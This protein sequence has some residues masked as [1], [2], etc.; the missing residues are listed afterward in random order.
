VGL[1]LGGIAAVLTWSSTVA[2]TVANFLQ[3]GTDV[4][5]KTVGEVKRELADE[6]AK[7]KRPLL[8]I[9]DDIDRL[10]PREA[11]EIFQL[12]KIN[13]DFPNLVYLLLFDRKL[14]EKSVEELMPGS[15]REFLEKIVQVPFDVPAIQQVQLEKVL[16]E[17]IDRIL[18][19]PGI[20]QRFDR[21][22]WGNLY[23]GALRPFFE[24]LRDVNRY[25][26]TLSFHAGLYKGERTFEVNPVDLIGLEVLRVFT[27]DVYSLVARNK[28]LLTSLSDRRNTDETKGRI[29]A[30]IESA[31]EGPRPMVTELMKQLFPPV[32]WALNGSL[33]GAN[34]AGTWLRDLRVCSETVFDRYFA[35]TVPSGDLPQSDVDRLLQSSADREQLRQ[36]LDSLADRGLINL[37]LERLDTFQEQIPLQNARP[38]LAGLFDVG[39]RIPKE[40]GASFAISP[41][42]HAIRIVYWYLRRIEQST[43]RL[44]VLRQAIEESAGLSLPVRFVSIEESSATRGRDTSERIVDDEGLGL[45]KELCV[46]KIEQAAADGRLA[47]NPFL[48]QVLYRWTEWGGSGPAKGFCQRFLATPGDVARFLTLFVQTSFSQGMR[49]FVS[50]EN[51]YIGL[52]NVERLLPWTEIERALAGF[53]ET[54][55][56]KEEER[57]AVELFR[58]AVARRRAGK[59]D[60]GE[61][62]FD[63][64]E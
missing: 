44:E 53:D 8:V 21:Q 11:Q 22:R 25:L 43:E 4:G 41:E 55:V 49:D 27:P 31:D 13:G 42:M 46:K 24:T 12:I 57:E 26:S 35:F 37:A 40:R 58:K 6:L 50:R 3:I 5:A 28:E 60:Y 17:G 39:E 23:V 61:A 20:G 45:L 59:P 48:V 33:Y 56:E 10:T 14:V 36:A 18:G 34:F 52:S 29:M 16:F 9:L 63:D 54:T 62:A 38:F 30:M 47:D 15:G 64:E 2:E 7:L 1:V 32:E 51:R 19:E